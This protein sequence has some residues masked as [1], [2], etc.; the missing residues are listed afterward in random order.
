MEKKN[1]HIYMY[2][3]IYS[4]SIRPFIWEYDRGEKQIVFQLGNSFGNTKMEEITYISVFKWAIHLE[5][6]KWESPLIYAFSIGQFIWE[7]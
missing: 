1:T 6:L 4:F 7:D 3:Y 2:I 5:I